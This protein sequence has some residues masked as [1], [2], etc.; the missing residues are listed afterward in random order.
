MADQLWYV[1]GPVGNSDRAVVV[2]PDVLAFLT[3][4]A[5]PADFCLFALRCCCFHLK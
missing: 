3:P 4:L 1:I 5:A 2:Y